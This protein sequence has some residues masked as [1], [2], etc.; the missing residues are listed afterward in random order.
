MHSDGHREICGGKIANLH[1]SGLEELRPINLSGIL[2][3]SNDYLAPCRLDLPG[4]KL[5]KMGGECFI[6][7]SVMPL[8]TS[9]GMPINPAVPIHKLAMS[10]QAA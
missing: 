2:V 7:P 10:K 9:H 6:V 1:Y 5:V 3:Q 8:C 4:E